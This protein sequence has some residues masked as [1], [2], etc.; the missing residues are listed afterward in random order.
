[1]TETDATAV[2]EAIAAT[3]PPEAVHDAGPFR[4]AQ[5]SGG[6]N[7]VSAARLRDPCAD[8]SGVTAAEIAAVAAHTRALGQEALFMVFGWQAPLDRLLET[9]GYGMRDATDMLCSAVSRVAAPPPPV[10]C[11]DIWPPLAVQ[12]DIWAAGGIGPARLAVMHRVP[13]P[14]TTIFGRIGDRPAG[15]AFVAVHRDVAMLHAL[16]VSPGSRRRGLARTMVHA[17]AHWAERHGAA[18]FSALV[19]RENSA[20]QGLYASLGL[21]AVGQ[22]HYRAK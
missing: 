8:G 2:A 19:T 14:R 12:E 16:E 21:A 5:G 13:G 6:G 22:Y 3:W 7:R 11:F 15:T 18:V 10:T 9:E 17:A 20:A 1:M 4:L